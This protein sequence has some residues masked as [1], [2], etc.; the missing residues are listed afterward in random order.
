VGGRL[1]D[2]GQERLLCTAWTGSSPRV[3]GTPPRRDQGCRRVRFG[4]VSARAERKKAR[5]AAMSRCSLSLAALVALSGD[6]GAEIEGRTADQE[7]LHQVV[8]SQPV[9][10]AP[11]H[12]ESDHVRGVVGVV[13][14]AAATLIVLFAARAAAEPTIAPGRALQPLRHSDGAA[15]Q[16][17]N[18]Q[19]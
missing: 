18:S 16:R 14:Q 9:T 11:E 1:T 13:Q 6:R 15:G 19:L 4:S 5:A 3:R 8:Q 12:R 7:H 17:S 2:G 10:Q